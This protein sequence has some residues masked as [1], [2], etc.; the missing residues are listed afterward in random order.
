M[1]PDPTETVQL[2]RLLAEL[3]YPELPHDI[4]W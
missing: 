1:K 2:L 3:A 4:L